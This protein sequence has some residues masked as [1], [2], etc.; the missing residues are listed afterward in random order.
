M[1]HSAMLGDKDWD[2][3][4]GNAAGRKGDQGRRWWYFAGS[5]DT[6]PS[7]CGPETMTKVM[8]IA[9][10]AGLR[11]LMLIP[12]LRVYAPLTNSNRYSGTVGFPL[13]KRLRLIDVRVEWP[14]IKYEYRAID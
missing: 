7:L 13:H 10:E 12:N 11:L 1:P 3:A 5:A 9:F 6:H 8:P 2:V 14:I 4:A